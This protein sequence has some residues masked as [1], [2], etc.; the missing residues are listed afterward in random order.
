MEKIENQ[1]K[2]YYKGFTFIEALV[3]LFLFSVIVTTF[4]SVF[5]L[6][7][8][9]IIDSKNRLS[10]VS[11]ANQKME[12]IRNLPY[13]NVGVIDGIPNG[14]I[15]PDEI[16]SVNGRNFRVLTDIKYYDDSFDGTLGGDPDDTIPNDYK[17]VRV[18][19][20]WGQEASSQQV[21]L[22]STFVPPGREEAAGGGTLAINA[23]DSSGMGVPSVSVHILNSETSINLNTATD[24][25]GNLILPATPAASPNTYEI[26]LSKSGYETVATLPQYPTNPYHPIEVHTS[27]L[28]G[29]LTQKTIIINPLSNVEIA[30]VDP[31]GNV[32]SDI[33]FNL[34]GGRLLGNEDGTGNP[35]YNYDQDLTTD[36]NGE[37][38]L[39]DT[40]PG[41]YVFSLRGTSTADYTMFKMNPGA[42]LNENE[43]ILLAGDSLSV[44]AVIADQSIP[45]LM[46]T[47]K[48]DLG[49]PIEGAS[50]NLVNISQ[51]Y[52]VTLTTDK[53]GK[54][55]FPDDTLPLI[56]D[57]Y[58]IEINADGFNDEDS[59]VTIN[60]LTE[61]EFSLT[62]S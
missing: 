48:N 37:F 53:Y 62:P 54:V 55:Y 13:S 6:G 39:D 49:N 16:E 25:E 60:N 9:H 33:E 47:V 23:M 46:A 22:A 30:T 18:T 14:P 44:S 4:Y 17:V 3:V 15:D 42:D 28:E 19:V 20:K 43:F 7:T 45:S 11:L 51:S 50:V 2:Q 38:S 32:I 52:D 21:F 26:T 58:D 10:A 1:N 27:V 61:E 12:I 35:I 34:E 40:S 36:S 24:S 56:N 41:T 5:S 31:L 29:E 57:D 8:K 59:T